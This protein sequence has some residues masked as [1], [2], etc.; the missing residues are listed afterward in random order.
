MSKHLSEKITIA[1]I[2]SDFNV[3]KTTVHKCIKQFKDNSSLIFNDSSI[4]QRN[5]Y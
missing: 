1:Q 3:S 5:N 2:C 4:S